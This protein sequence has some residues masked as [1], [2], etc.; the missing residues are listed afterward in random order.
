MEFDKCKNFDSIFFRIKR[1]ISP[2]WQKKT[3]NGQ[4]KTKK[5]PR[6]RGVFES[7]YAACFSFFRFIWLTSESRA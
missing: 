6:P 3:G 5:R 7:R 1:R 2:L 4:R